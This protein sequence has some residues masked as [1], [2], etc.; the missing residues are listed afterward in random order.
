MLAWPTTGIFSVVNA[1]LL[2]PSLQQSRASGA[3]YTNFLLPQWRLPV[4]WTRPE[5]WTWA[6]P[7]I[8]DSIDAWATRGANIAGISN[9]PV[10]GLCQR[11]LLNSLGVCA[12][13]GRLITPAMT[14]RLRP[15]RRY[16]FGYG[17]PVRRIRSGWRQTCSADRMHHHRRDAAWDSVSPAKSPPNSGPRCK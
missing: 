13:M 11:R 2:R 3:I 8:L 5:F 10:T 14:R 7:E 17:K 9:P 16:S 4:F 6:G 12:M 15:S 1:V